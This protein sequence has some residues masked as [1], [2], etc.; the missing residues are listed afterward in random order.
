MDFGPCEA[1]DRLTPTGIRS[2]LCLK[3]VSTIA[4]L[5]A[6]WLHGRQYDDGDTRTCSIAG[7]WDLSDLRRATIRAGSKAC[8]RM[9]RGSSA[10][11]S[12]LH[13]L[14]VGPSNQ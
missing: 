13:R 9:L 2:P 10:G 7:H 1:F 4:P 11:I 12:R 3:T 14:S 8:D 6:A 5:G